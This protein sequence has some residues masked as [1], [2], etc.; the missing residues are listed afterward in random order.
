MNQS[1]KTNPQN[2]ITTVAVLVGLALGL[3]LVC[4]LPRL[5][6]LRLLALLLVFLLSM[7]VALVLQLLLHEMGHCLLGL[8]TGYRLVSFR[9]GN[10]LFLREGGRWRCAQ[11]RLPGT[12]GQCLMAPP[13]REPFPCALYNLGGILL[14][15]LSA[16]TALALWICLP[17]SPWSA[18]PLWTFLATGV[19]FALANAVPRL[20]QG[21]ANDGY[22]QRC[23]RRNPGSREAFRNTLRIHARLAQGDRLRDMPD[24]WFRLPK[25]ADQASPLVCGLAVQALSRQLDLQQLAGA[26]AACDRLLQAPGLLGLHRSLVQGELLYLELLGPRRRDWIDALFTPELRSFL[27][28]LQGTNPTALRLLYAQALLAAEDEEAANRYLEAFQAL[29]E[30]YP[31]RGDYAQEQELVALAQRVFAGV[32][33]TG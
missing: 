4:F 25:N 30:R 1:P 11:F 24:A 21:V 13:D 15:L 8:L 7:A 16:L 5:G 32:G 17:R 26:R 6:P 10:R 33:P 19:A 23:L 18:I 28:R 31:Y 20:D 29:G 2:R 12:A 3:V 27:E 22:N 9:L 14:N